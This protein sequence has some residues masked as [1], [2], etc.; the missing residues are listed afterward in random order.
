MEKERREAVVMMIRTIPART[1]FDLIE[2]LCEQDPHADKNRLKF[3]LVSLSE[4]L[5]YEFKPPE[6]RRK[7]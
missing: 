3:A 4:T 1:L 7:E 2:L 5:E 6:Q